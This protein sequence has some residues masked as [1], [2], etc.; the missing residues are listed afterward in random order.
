MVTTA[1]L[2]KPVREVGS[3]YALS[4]DTFVH[5]VR[6]P[7]AWREFVNQTWFVARVSI[8]PT[9]LMSIPWSAFII[10]ILNV[11]LVEIGAADVSGAAASLA[12]VVYI[13]PL[14]TVLVL[15][16][17]SATAMCAD[18]G[19][20]T[21]REEIDALRVM[22]IDPVPA[23]AVPRVLAAGVNGLLLNAINT[24][25]GLIAC[26]AFSVY[27]QHVNPGSYAASLTLLVGLP[28]IAIAFLKAVCFGVVAGLI[29]CYK[30]LTVGGGPQGVGNAVN[31]TV[32][33]TFMALYVINVVL[34][35]IGTKATM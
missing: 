7:F 3:F 17:T 8:V 15:A 16:G 25:A 1:T 4:L 30:G 31:E 33:Y 24:T 5:M 14:G 20:R 27:F 29:A 18:L 35:A 22:G 9:M 6:P 19:A 23:L 11:L 32:V 28:D 21:I 10:F 2:V 34:V 12:V 26:Y 13:G